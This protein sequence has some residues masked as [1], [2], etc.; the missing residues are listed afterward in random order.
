MKQLSKLKLTKI[1]RVEKA[2]TQT[3]HMRKKLIERLTEQMTMVKTEE[4]GEEFIR[5]QTVWVT[6]A[7]GE[8]VA[9]TKP[10]RTRRWY[11]KADDGTWYFHLLYGNSV[12]EIDKGRTAIDVGRHREIKRAIETLMVATKEG[13]LDAALNRAFSKRKEQMKK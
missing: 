2:E 7:E 13:E 5:T 8:R 4:D 1:E 3:T 9:E 6:N 12:M 10:L 11:W